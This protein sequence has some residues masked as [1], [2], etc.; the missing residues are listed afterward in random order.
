MNRLLAFLF[1]CVLSF[2]ARAQYNDTLYY[3]SGMVKAVTIRQHDEKFLTYE[4]GGKG[5]KL[6]SAR[7]PI[8]KLKSFVIYNEYNE[9]V[10]DSRN[11]KKKED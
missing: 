8:S 7:I 6:V 11:P 10:Y 2:G 5:G 3:K 9:L 1:F 4:Y